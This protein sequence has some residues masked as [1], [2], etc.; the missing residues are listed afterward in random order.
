MICCT[1]EWT[2]LVVAS[3]FRGSC[4]YHVLDHIYHPTNCVLV[5]VYV[6]CICTNKNQCPDTNFQQ[7]NI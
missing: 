2:L 4:G 6:Q 3:C 5:Y 7:V 1:V